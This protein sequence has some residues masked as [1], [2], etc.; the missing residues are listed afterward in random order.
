MLDASVTRRLAGELLDPQNYIYIGA[1]DLPDPE[2]GVRLRRGMESLDVLFSLSP[3]HLD[4]W[5]F[6]RDERG[7]V[8][9]GN[10]GSICF[11][12][13]ALEKIVS[14]ISGSGLNGTIRAN[15]CSARTP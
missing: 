2:F 6:Q 8:V 7:K 10:Q 9:H 13:D 12:G 15:P 1:D 11:G 5:A 3:G 4:V 14:G